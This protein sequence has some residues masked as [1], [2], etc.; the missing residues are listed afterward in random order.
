MFR[1]ALLQDQ[2]KMRD[3]I[4]LHFAP[5]RTC[6]QTV[7]SFQCALQ[8][9]SLRSERPIRAQHRVTAVSPMLPVKLDQCLSGLAI[10]T[11]TTTTTTTKIIII[12]INL[13]HIAQFDTNGIL[14][15]LYIVI[16][17]TQVQYVYIR[18]YLKQSYSYTYTCLHINTYTDTCTN[19]HTHTHTHTHNIH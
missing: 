8:M 7:S 10:I 2:I 4:S 19:T 13:F 15:A 1:N 14:T 18:T 16:M 11:T 5:Y 12:V 9:A 3:V 6:P 17:Y